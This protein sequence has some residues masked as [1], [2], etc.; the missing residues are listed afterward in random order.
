MLRPGEAIRSHRH[1]SSTV[2][3]VVRGT[4]ESRVGKSKAEENTLQWGE[5]DCFNIPT[6]HWHR[7]TNRSSDQVAILF[8]VSDR[9][10]FQA[11][12]LYREQQ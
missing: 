5:R 2:Y 10:L 11:L 1:A 12:G 9:P 4:G 3:F 6:W 8:S 7:F